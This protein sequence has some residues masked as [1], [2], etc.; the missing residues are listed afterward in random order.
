MPDPTPEVDPDPRA[1]LLRLKL[2]ALVRGHT[3]TEVVLAEES[4]RAV[5]IVDGE[6]WFLAD[7]LGRRGLGPALAWAR[8]AGVARLHVIVDET[9]GAGGALA[10]AG[11]CLCIAAVGLGGAGPRARTGPA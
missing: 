4:T 6:G 10:R 7:D 9:T 1:G 5:A 8:Q 3:G 2:A 11:P